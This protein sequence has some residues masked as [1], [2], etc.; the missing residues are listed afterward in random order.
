MPKANTVTVWHANEPTWGRTDPVWNPANYTMVAIVN[1]FS[2]A[3][4]EPVS[5]D[6]AYQLTNHIDRAWWDN[7]NVTRV[8]PETRSTSVGDVIFRDG[9][10]HR[11]ASFGF[12]KLAK[13]VA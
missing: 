4:A 5:L 10:A 3:S 12:D 8:G 11:V 7:T 2:D 1:P 13:E 9:V 6:H